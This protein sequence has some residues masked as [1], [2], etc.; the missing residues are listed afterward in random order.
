MGCMTPFMLLY[1]GL[2]HGVHDPFYAV[3]CGAV[4][5]GAWPLLCCCMWG[6]HMGCMTPFMLL[7]VALSHGV[8]D[9]FYAVVCGAVTWGA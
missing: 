3:V 6:C 7:Y 1:V 4:T 8:H 2:S 5:W 9:P